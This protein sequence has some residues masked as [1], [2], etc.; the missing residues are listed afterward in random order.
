[1]PRSGSRQ[2]RRACSTW[3]VEDRPD[4][5][6][7]AVARP[8]VQVDRV[9]HRAP[10]VVLRLAVGGVADANRPRAL[11]A[12]EVVE[13]R[14][15]RAS[16]SPPTPYIT[17]SLLVRRGHL[18][19]RSR[20]SRWPPSRSR[21]CT[22]PTARRSSR[23]PSCSGSP[24]CARRRASP[25]SEVVAAA[26]IAPVGAYVSPLSV[27]ARCA[28]GACATGGPGSCRARASAASGARSTRSRG[29]PPRRSIG[30]GTSPQDSAA[31]RSSPSL[32]ASGRARAGP[33]KPRLMSLVSVSVRSE[34]GDRCTRAGGSRRRVNVPAGR[35][36]GRSRRRARSRASAATSPFTQRTVRMSVCVG[37]VVGRGAPVLVGGAVRGVV[38]RTDRRARPG[39]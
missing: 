30:G 22:G 14:L 24:S 10:D 21:A 38:P 39:R 29:R 36:A 3:R 12:E 18:E 32:I 25:G 33:S 27:S 31:K 17:W 9:E 26:T 5:L 8:G 16:R 7:E 2:W 34:P 19:R 1:M 35:A 28:G 13:R 6:V 15:G 20:R 37:G 4:P 23:G 11:V